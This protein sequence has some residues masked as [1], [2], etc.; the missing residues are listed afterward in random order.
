MYGSI[1]VSNGWVNICKQW[2]GQYTCAMYGSIYVSYGWVSICDQCM[3]QY[4]GAMDGSVYVSNRWVEGEPGG[5][6]GNRI[7]KISSHIVIK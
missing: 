3:G 7:L 4:T 2:M 6:V 1:Y 5:L